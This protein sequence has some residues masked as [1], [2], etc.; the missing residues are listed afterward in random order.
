MHGGSIVFALSGWLFSTWLYIQ[1]FKVLANESTNLLEQREES[2]LRQG[3]SSWA[4]LPF[5]PQG[6]EPPLFSLHLAAQMAR[7][8]IGG[9]KH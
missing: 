6:G 1:T 4:E 7:K 8:L 3:Q 2:I 9:R 5:L